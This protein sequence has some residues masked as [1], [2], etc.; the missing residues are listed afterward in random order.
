MPFNRLKLVVIPVLALTSIVFATD[1]PFARWDRIN[2]LQEQQESAAL[3]REAEK[4]TLVA[5]PGA[6]R[7]AEVTRT[8]PQ[9]QG[10]P[11]KRVAYFSPNA[12]P[13]NTKL[14]TGAVSPPLPAQTS[15]G[16]VNERL[17]VKPPS[18]RGTA[19]RRTNRVQP[20]SYTPQGGRVIQQTSSESVE[21][22]FESPFAELG[23]PETEEFP[24][25]DFASSLESGTSTDT[26]VSGEMPAA[27]TAPNPFEEFAPADTETANPFA[28]AETLSPVAVETELPFNEP[29]AEENP[30]AIAPF[31]P[32]V[33][34][35]PD[36]VTPEIEE[37]Q[38]PASEFADSGEPAVSSDATVRP[39]DAG[40]Q[41]PTVTIRWEHDGRFNVG[42]QCPCIM[43]VENTGSSAV[44]N[45]VA[46]AVLPAGL[47]VI[48][49]EPAPVATGE[50]ATWTFG[51]LKAGQSRSVKLV[52][53][54]NGVGD[55]DL[56]AF[57]R[58]TGATSSRFTVEQPL[59]AVA[60]TGPE[61]VEV[62]QSVNYTVEVSNPGTG[63]ANNVVIQAMIPPGLQHRRG[64]ILTI[65]IG[66]LNSGESRRA[67]LSLTGVAG[68]EQQLAVRVVGDGD[69]SEE[70]VET[71]N[72]AEPKLNIAVRGPA[73]PVAQE[74]ANY[75]VVVVNEG[76]VDSNNVRAK[77]RVPAGF[78]YV[79]ADRGGKF[80]KTDGTI[81]W[82]VGTLEPGKMK[83]M[84][85]SLRAIKDGNSKHQVGVISEH[86][87]MTLAEHKCQVQGMAVL[88]VKLASDAAR[89]RSNGGES[90]FEIRI[91][92]TGT[93]AA[94]G[95]GL[96]C[97]VPPAMELVDVSGPSEYIADSG[98]IIFRSLPQLA[99]G[100][101]ATFI[102]RTRCARAGKHTARIRVASKSVRKAL[103]DEVSVT[104][105][106]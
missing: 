39:G 67:R 68:G 41:S 98:V 91:S 33:P 22:S 49:A 2:K 45:V 88:D 47:E 62:G 37:S 94:E 21:T 43:V 63:L 25:A 104:G 35:L 77:Y 61:N 12:K 70:T 54:P 28:A 100:E 52:V 81:E 92:N 78:D 50:S 96:S 36:F 101:T 99:P 24:F 18:V 71:V 80:N 64:K 13:A 93:S 1:N 76:R 79:S 32:E 56:N 31:E 69:L 10:Q 82:F 44:R 48:A 6:Q 73:T 8:K 86:G 95:V 106:N 105:V 60:V 58:F 3:K 85:V 46:E 9:Q 55:V 42:Q 97:E 26:A 11:R 40:P 17:A 15:N 102:V 51:E 75:E 30:F 83:H 53:V 16:I 65:D 84:T 20:A 27:E 66:T 87:K 74:A 7:A 72:V 57:V 29:A 5:R 14:Q 89:V 38:L 90:S 19:D 23:E 4:D 34:E 59:L 103:I